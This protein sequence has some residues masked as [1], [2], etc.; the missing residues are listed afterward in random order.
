[1]AREISSA[2]ESSQPAERLSP[3]SYVILVL[4]GRDG[5]GPHDLRRNAETGRL[6]W[7]AAPSQ[8]YAEPKRLARLGLLEARKEPG[9]TRQRTHYTLTDAGR[10]AVEAWVRTPTPLPKMQH[11]TIVRLLAADLVPAEAVLAGLDDLDA[12]LD[13][14]ERA[15]TEAR[16][17][18]IGG[19]PHR[20]DLLEVNHLYGRRLFDL[21]R[22]W[23]ADARRLLAQRAAP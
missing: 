8:W 22:A 12:Q 10:A 13:E 3:F 2:S 1:M 9:R 4:V 7:D 5:A 11:E 17:T 15:M 23:S 6:Y 19:L 14:A 21:L 16:A 20:A 18:W